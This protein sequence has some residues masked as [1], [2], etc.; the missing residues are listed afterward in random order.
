MADIAEK[1]EHQ[2]RNWR[3]VAI[4]I[5]QAAIERVGRKTCVECGSKIP[6]GRI[7]SWCV[8]CKTRQ[9]NKGLIRR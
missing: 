7:S 1:S 5:A 3:T 4:G 6:E 2:E 8:P 9:E